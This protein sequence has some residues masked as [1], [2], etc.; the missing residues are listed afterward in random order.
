MDLLYV[1]L[2]SFIL[3]L[4]AWPACVCSPCVQF[5]RRPEEGVRSLELETQTAVSGHMRTRNPKTFIL[6]TSN[7]CFN[8][9]SSLQLQFLL[10]NSDSLLFMELGMVVQ[11]CN[12]TFKRL[13]QKDWDF[14]IS[15]SN[16]PCYY[17]GVA[18]WEHC[19]HVAD[20]KWQSLLASQQLYLAL[21][22]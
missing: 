5:L 1:G 10:F 16:L 18:I 14:E 13:R 8:G 12:S 22:L 7:W 4:G 6:W 2:I 9:E 21:S 3:C 20:I 19:S 11:V 17:C 15:L